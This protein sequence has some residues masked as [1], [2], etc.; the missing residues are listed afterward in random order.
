MRHFL[1][2][3]FLLLLV[4]PVAGRDLPKL[5]ADRE[6]PRGTDSPG[7]VVFSHKSHV[8]SSRPDCTT[9]HSDPFR[10]L[11]AK[12]GAPA[13]VIRHADMEKGKYC[14]RCHDGKSAFGFDDCTMC[15]RSE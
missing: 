9:C 7:K 8:D 1:V 2:A 3:S 13:L 15:H 12:A 11:P 4:L 10:I 6:V 5:P 14:G